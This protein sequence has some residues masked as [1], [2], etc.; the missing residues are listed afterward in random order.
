MQFICCTLYHIDIK[1]LYWWWQCIRKLPHQ[2]HYNC[3]TAKSQLNYWHFFWKFLESFQHLTVVLS[4]F[5][6]SK[7][8]FTCRAP[9]LGEEDHFSLYLFNFFVSLETSDLHLLLEDFYHKR[10]VLINRVKIHLKILLIKLCRILHTDRKGRF[11]CIWPFCG[12][13]TERVKTYV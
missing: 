8:D 2:V 3:Y 7:S 10:I 12:I 4:E 13:G 11:E 5:N 1:I 6:F 9:W